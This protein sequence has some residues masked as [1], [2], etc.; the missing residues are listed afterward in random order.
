MRNDGNTGLFDFFLPRIYSLN[1]AQETFYFLYVSIQSFGV[2]SSRN[3][4]NTG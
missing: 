3:P 1:I 4:L 2:L